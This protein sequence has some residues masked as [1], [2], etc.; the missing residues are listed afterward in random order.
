MPAVIAQF[1][2][3]LVE[4]SRPDLS[5]PR[6]PFSRLAAWLEDV[7]RRQVEREVGRLIEHEGGRLTD[8]LE[9]RI[10]RHFV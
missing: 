3:A 10:E 6:G 1:A 8:G 9:R 7:R 4:A 2:P 5:P